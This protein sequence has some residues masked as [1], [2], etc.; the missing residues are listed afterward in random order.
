MVGQKLGVRGGEKVVWGPA[1]PSSCATEPG[2]R[3]DVDRLLSGLLGP[4]LFLN[5]RDVLSF[6]R[7]E[8]CGFAGSLVGYPLSGHANEL[9]IHIFPLLWFF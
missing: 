7:F 3:D 5:D 6:L 1:C 9:I 2:H 8:P 4:F